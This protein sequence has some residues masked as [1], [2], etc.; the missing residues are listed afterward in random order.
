MQNARR[1]MDRLAWLAS[2]SS[3]AGYCD[4]AAAEFGQSGDIV[5]MI[6]LGQYAEA[7]EVYGLV[8]QAL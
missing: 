1:R 3:R 4:E 6:A 7:E 5:D 2:D 8:L